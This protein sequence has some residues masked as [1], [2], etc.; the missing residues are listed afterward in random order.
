MSVKI[1]IE[2]ADKIICSSDQTQLCKDKKAPGGS[3]FVIEAIYDYTPIAEE[4]D[5]NLDKRAGMRAVFPLSL[6]DDGI[7]IVNNSGDL[8]VAVDDDAPVIFWISQTG[9]DANRINTLVSVGPD[10]PLIALRLDKPDNI[11]PVVLAPDSVSLENQDQFQEPLGGPGTTVANLVV[12][13]EADS[14]DSYPLFI[15]AVGHVESVEQAKTN[16]AEVCLVLI[17]AGKGVYKAILVQPETVFGPPGEGRREKCRRWQNR[18]G[19]Y[20]RW[21]RN[22]YGCPHYY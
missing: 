20:Y 15:N 18:R 8:R 17:S 5:W 6:E 12:W 19:W 11:Q 21:L 22:W 7:Q 2:H 10:E 14:G 3:R 13:L 9:G 4:R 16:F 1:H